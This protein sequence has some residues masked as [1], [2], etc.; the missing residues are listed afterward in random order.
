MFPENLQQQQPCTP[1][2]HSQVNFTGKTLTWC[3]DSLKRTLEIQV[4]GSVGQIIQQKK[5]PKQS[6]SIHYILLF[7]QEAPLS[8]D[9][10]TKRNMAKVA[11]IQTQYILQM[12]QIQHKMQ[13]L[14]HDIQYTNTRNKETQVACQEKT[15]SLLHHILGDAFRFSNRV[16]PTS[17][18]TLSPSKTIHLEENSRKILELRHNKGSE[19]NWKYTQ[20]RFTDTIFI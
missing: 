18:E 12:P 20:Y 16:F 19:V 14:Q 2:M 17:V 9:F 10:L 15:T 7:N 1:A 6:F 3:Y 13:A 4:Q 11:A 8:W 5:P